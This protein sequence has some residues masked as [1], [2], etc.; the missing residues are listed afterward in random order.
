MLIFL[1]V[2]FYSKRKWS[3][4]HERESAFWQGNGLL[5]LGESQP[6]WRTKNQE[7][8][9]SMPATFSGVELAQLQGNSIPPR[10]LCKGCCHQ[11]GTLQFP[12]TCVKYQHSVNYSQFSGSKCVSQ[13]S[14]YLHE[15]WLLR[16]ERFWGLPLQLTG[17]GMIVRGLK[18]LSHGEQQ[19]GISLLLFLSPSLSTEWCWLLAKAWKGRLG[20]NSRGRRES[21]LNHF[22]N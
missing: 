11:H 14:A 20:E 3:V 12:L 19:A 18:S 16:G 5:L 1:F 17:S 10:T 9:W 6:M 21:T 15:Q 13:G 8:E 2:C 22:L 4:V 7:K